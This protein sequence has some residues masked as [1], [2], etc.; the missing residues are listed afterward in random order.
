MLFLLEQLAN[1]CS[2]RNQTWVAR[3]QVRCCNHYTTNTAVWVKLKL[4]LYKVSI[5][6]MVLNKTLA[7]VCKVSQ[8]YNKRRGCWFPKCDYLGETINVFYCLCFYLLGFI[9]SVRCGNCISN[10]NLRGYTVLLDSLVW[11]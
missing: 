10:V 6:S 1:S 2:W 5:Y 8:K 9:F 11:D 7:Y 3:M 4:F